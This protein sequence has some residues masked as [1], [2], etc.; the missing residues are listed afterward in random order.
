MSN[1]LMI[2]AGKDTLMT[3]EQPRMI[4]EAA[5]EPKRL[6]VLD[7][8]THHDIYRPEYFERVICAAVDW[9]DKRLAEV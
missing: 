2:V 1:L 9:L 4:F 5:A 6:V 3:P 7:D 8:A